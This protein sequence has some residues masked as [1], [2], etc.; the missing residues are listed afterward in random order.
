VS[1]RSR[2]RQGEKAPRG[3]PDRVVVPRDHVLLLP[4]S[5]FSRSGM[6]VSLVLAYHSRRCY[7][8]S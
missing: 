6:F 4:L 1:N 2:W 5:S 8:T 3:T 7:G